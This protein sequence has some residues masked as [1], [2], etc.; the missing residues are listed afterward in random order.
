MKKL[1]DLVKMKFRKTI[2]LF[3]DRS[4]DIQSS[5]GRNLTDITGREKDGVLL[6]SRGIERTTY[7][8]TKYRA[9]WIES[10]RLCSLV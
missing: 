10:N 7:H 4:G 9:N 3:F 8:G 1:R 2:F 6:T 5:I